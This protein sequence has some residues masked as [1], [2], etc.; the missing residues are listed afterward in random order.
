AVP[1]GRLVVDR[2][3]GRGLGGGGVV[4]GA[5]GGK[6]DGEE[7]GKAHGWLR[8]CLQADTP[9]TGRGFRRYALTPAREPVAHFLSRTSRTTD[10]GTR[11][12]VAPSFAGLPRNT[13]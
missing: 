8:R 10:F 7:K 11:R 3:C 5:P 13:T 12:I 6:R 1:A 9:T 2:R 4:P